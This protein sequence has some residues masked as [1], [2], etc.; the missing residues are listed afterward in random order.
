MIGHVAPEAYVGGNIALV[1]DGDQIVID[2]ETNQIDLQISPDDMENRRKQWKPR[3]PNYESGALAK[4][5]SLV[6]SAAQGAVTSP[7]W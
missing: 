3:K 4:Y 5:A 2:T 7:V 1:H 6:G